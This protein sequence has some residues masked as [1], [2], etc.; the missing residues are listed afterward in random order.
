[1][2]TL[3]IVNK[4]SGFDKKCF[5]WQKPAAIL[6]AILDC[7]VRTTRLQNSPPVS[8]TTDILVIY[9]MFC[10]TFMATSPQKFT[11]CH[12]TINPYTVIC[13]SQQ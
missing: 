5:D 6:D 4:I 13:L 7:H 12:P 11:D 9:N 8:P 3:V 1:M 2:F 10:S